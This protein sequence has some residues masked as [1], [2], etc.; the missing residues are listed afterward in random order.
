MA[1]LWS[2]SRV[3]RGLTLVLAL[4]TTRGSATP[5]YQFA[6]DVAIEQQDNYHANT[7]GPFIQR[8]AGPGVSDTQFSAQGARQGIATLAPQDILAYHATLGSQLYGP[9][10][11]DSVEE[12][13]QLVTRVRE[14]SD[15]LKAKWQRK[16]T[17]LGAFKG[18][19]K[20]GWTEHDMSQ[21][22]EEDGSMKRCEPLFSLMRVGNNAL[23]RVPYNNEALTVLRDPERPPSIGVAPGGPN[24]MLRVQQDKTWSYEGSS[25]NRLVST[26]LSNEAPVYR[27]FRG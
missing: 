17:S 10:I 8:R 20:N 7:T 21:H 14:V 13:D 3:A 16:P 15:P 19:S 5:V 6:A 26:V 23:R 2:E 25:R 22:L 12:T 27:R 9:L 18:F 11:M 1:P 4:S 24:L